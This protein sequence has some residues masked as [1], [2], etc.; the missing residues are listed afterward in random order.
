[1]ERSAAVARAV[2]SG[3]AFA[4]AWAEGQAMPLEQ[5]A[6]CA[7]EAGGAEGPVPARSVGDGGPVSG[8]GT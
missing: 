3:E 2:L 7:L 6:H 5:A 1:M 8:G 4:A